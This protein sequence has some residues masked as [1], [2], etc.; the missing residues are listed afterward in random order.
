MASDRNHLILD[1]EARHYDMKTFLAEKSIADSISRLIRTPLKTELTRVRDWVDRYCEKQSI[2]LSQEQKQAVEQA[3]LSRVFVLTGGPGVGKTT[4]ANLIIRLFLAM[5][6]SV[7]LC[8]PT[9]RAAQRLSEVSQSPAKTIH[10]LLEWNP[11]Q[12]GFAL[13]QNNPLLAE[14]VIVDESSM[15]D[16]HLADS[17][18][19]AI[20]SKSQVIFIGDADQL[21]SVGPGQVLGDLI[22]SSCVPLSAWARFFGRLRLLLSSVLLMP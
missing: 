14:V 1:P 18:L 16:V 10:R 9:G 5:G 21:P 3:T 6:K 7:V 2:T 17:L 12:G 15:I 19:R 11:A 4:T 20:R 8:A 22:A 13:D